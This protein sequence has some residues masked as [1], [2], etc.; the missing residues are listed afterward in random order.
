MIGS[1]VVGTVV[2]VI[3]VAYWALGVGTSSISSSGTAMS[4]MM[5]STRA[6]WVPDASSLLDG[7]PLKS[8]PSA[9]SNNHLPTF[10]A[11]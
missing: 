10:P 9:I 11:A 7:V 2:L 6:A 5:P 8:S 3:G 4:L 1:S